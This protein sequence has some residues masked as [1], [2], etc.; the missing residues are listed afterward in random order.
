MQNMHILNFRPAQ[1]PAFC[2]LHFELLKA[3]VQQ[4]FHRKHFV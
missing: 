3:P 1:K 4:I 2:A